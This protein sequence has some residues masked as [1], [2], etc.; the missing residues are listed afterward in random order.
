VPRCIE[1]DYIGV[2]ARTLFSRV[3][4][5]D[6]ADDVDFIPPCQDGVQAFLHDPNIT[7]DQNAQRLACFPWHRLERLS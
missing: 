4:S 6:R 1:Q 3:Q 2:Q 5:V 7:H